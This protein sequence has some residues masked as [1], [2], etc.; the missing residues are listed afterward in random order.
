MGKNHV[1]CFSRR[2]CSGS[3]C[4]CH[5]CSC[6][7][8]A[9]AAVVVVVSVNDGVCCSHE[10]VLISLLVLI[11]KALS[12]LPQFLSQYLQPIIISVCVIMYSSLNTY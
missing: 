5:F 11:H 3:S 8:V 7:V 4:S 12:H 6:C 10:T 1:W 9:V 2:S